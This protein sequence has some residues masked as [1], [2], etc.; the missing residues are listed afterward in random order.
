MCN[1]VTLA[2]VCSVGGN[3]WPFVLKTFVTQ[4]GAVPLKNFGHIDG[5]SSVA[6]LHDQSITKHPVGHSARACIT[7][8]DSFDCW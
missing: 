7:I 3:E 1:A 2:R 5:Y 6:L 4:G 8:P